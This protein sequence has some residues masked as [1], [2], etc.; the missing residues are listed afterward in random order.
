MYDLN[1][2]INIVNEIVSNFEPTP[3]LETQNFPLRWEAEILIQ[4]YDFD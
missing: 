4:D 2:I 3:I 1:E